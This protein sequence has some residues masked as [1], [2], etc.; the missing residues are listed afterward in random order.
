MMF[1]APAML[2]GAALAA[3]PVLIHLINRRRYR[4]IPWAAMEFLSAIDARS[5]RRLRIEDWLLVALRTLVILLVAFAASRPVIGTAPGGAVILID[6]S[7]SMRAID[8]GKMRFDA[9]REAAAEIARALPAGATAALV[10]FDI[11]AQDVSGGSTSREA[12]TEALDTLSPGWCGTDYGAALEAAAQTAD[13]FA[14]PPAVVIV[15]DFHGGAR[16]LDGA[17]Q[18]PGARAYLLPV[19]GPVANRAVWGIERAGAAFTSEAMEVSVSLL[20]TAPARETVT[21]FTRVDAIT[22]PSTE[23]DIPAGQTTSVSLA[24]QRLAAA[25]SHRVE[26]A[27]SPDGYTPDDTAFA[28]IE[29]RPVRVAV[30]ASGDAKRFLDAAIGAAAPGSLAAASGG[31]SPDGY[32]LAGAYPSGDTAADIWRRV[33]AGG[34]AVVFLDPVS[35][36][37]A[38][39]FVHASGDARLEKLTDARPIAGPLSFTLLGEH[40]ITRFVSQTSALSIAA[41]P[42]AKALGI[43]VSETGTAIPVVLERGKERHAFLAL[44]YAGAGRVAVLNC[45]AD[46]TTGDLPV[47]PFFV[48]LLFETIAWASEAGSGRTSFVC[49]ESALIGVA[50]GEGEGTPRAVSVPREPGFH[51]VSGREIAV[52]VPREESTLAPADRAQVERALG[53]RFSDTQQVVAAL[54]G[55]AGREVSAWFFAAALVLLAAEMGL[56]A[57]LRRRA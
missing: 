6:R 42:V 34:F 27:I 35:A 24:A 26:A 31:D 57:W 8:G 46:R 4:A 51:N 19:G 2:F 52:N 29:T 9:A 40:R 53:G 30:S 3:A 36:G 7:A 5:S 38:A 13:G 15:S 18:G 17:G 41:V 14:T 43:P 56:V 22:G 12:V 33:R 21:V 49:G 1:L 32:I 45:A 11:D 37:A 55:G 39:G 10:A 54:G 28:V 47:T 23:A 50:G 48:P 16:G 44:F 25:G 20:N